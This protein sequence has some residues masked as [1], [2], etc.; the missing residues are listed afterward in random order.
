M[1]MHVY[2]VSLITN[3][4]TCVFC[5]TE[6]ARRDG[7]PRSPMM[8]AA[9]L[10]RGDRLGGGGLAGGALAAL[11]DALGVLLKHPVEEVVVVLKL[12]QPDYAALTTSN[13]FTKMPSVR[14]RRSRSKV[15]LAHRER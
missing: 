11:A 12:L 14:P 3:L 10:D 1:V 13:G 4:F 15:R 7:G 6:K 5:K 2:P 8:M 9:R